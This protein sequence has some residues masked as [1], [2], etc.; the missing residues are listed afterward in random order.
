MLTLVPV[1][2]FSRRP[3]LRLLAILSRSVNVTVM[4]KTCVFVET[5]E[6]FHLSKCSCDVAPLF[7]GCYIGGC[8]KCWSPRAVSMRP[9]HSGPVSVSFRTSGLV[10]FGFGQLASKL[11]LDTRIPWVGGGTIALGR[12][13]D[14]PTEKRYTDVPLSSPA[15]TRDNGRLVQI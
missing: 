4:R 12:F 5:T 2:Y 11:S 13:D 15:V 14:Q 6:E 10:G 8:R 3:T 1:E 7:N 9:F